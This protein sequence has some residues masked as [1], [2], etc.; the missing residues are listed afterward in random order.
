MRNNENKPICFACG[1]AC[2]KQLPGIVHPRDI[3][4]VTV[5]KLLKLIKE[6]YQFDYWEGNLTGLPE[7][8]GMT[9]Y[10]LRPMTIKSAGKPV[11]ASWGGQCVFWREKTGCTKSWDE[12]PRQCRA[13]KPKKEETGN[14]TVSKRYSKIQMIKDWIPYN[15]IIVEAID[16]AYEE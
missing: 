13:L 7:H 5:K 8:S 3:G 15:K 10:Y 6:G 9:F 14:C 1:G 12:R 11:D 16:K 2:C 4:K